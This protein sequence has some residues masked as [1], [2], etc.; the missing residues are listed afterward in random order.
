MKV[1]EV[2]GYAL[3]AL[4]A[5]LLVELFL[6]IELPLAGTACAVLLV[7]AGA[8]LMTGRRLAFGAEPEESGRPECAPQVRQCVLRR[9]TVDLTDTDNLPEYLQLRA[10]LGE[11]TV[12]LPV[13]AQVTVVKEGLACLIRTPDGVAT[14][15]GEEHMQCGSRD[16]SAPRLYVEAHALLGGVRFTLG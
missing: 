1:R 15:L 13:D 5:I 8:C 4:G 16:E 12:R 6:P 9:E 2:S 7:W 14:L 3:L 11:I 10:F